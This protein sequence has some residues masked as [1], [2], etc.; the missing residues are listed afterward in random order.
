M[1]VVFHCVA[2]YNILYKITLGIIIY[3]NFEFV[4]CAHIISLKITI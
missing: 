3:H 4:Q 1:G 2:S